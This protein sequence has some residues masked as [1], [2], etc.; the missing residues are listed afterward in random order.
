MH[1][2]ALRSN[3]GVF[4]GPSAIAPRHH[5]TDYPR[6]AIH[7]TN[8]IRTLILPKNSER[9]RNAEGDFPP[10][11]VGDSR[12]TIDE[13][14]DRQQPR[15]KVQGIA[16]ALLPYEPGGRVA[17]DAFAQQLISTH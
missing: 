9:L 17:V 14:V 1:Q 15:R 12:M 4:A 10:N 11:M 13:L 8:T 16:A 3:A 2:R 7:W 6:V 5:A